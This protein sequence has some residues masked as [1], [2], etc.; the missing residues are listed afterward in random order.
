[1]SNGENEDHYTVDADNIFTINELARLIQDEL[2]LRKKFFSDNILNGH[3]WD[4]L[5]RLLTATNE[6]HD[7]SV[8]A[9]S[10]LGGM[11]ATTGLRWIDVLRNEGLVIV[12]NDIDDGRKKFVFL[13]DQG[14]TGMESYLGAVAELRQIKMVS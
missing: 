4:V 9:I 7:S 2:K 11:Q 12:A 10:T 3:S 1:M 13:T 5:L 14:R 8:T 6:K